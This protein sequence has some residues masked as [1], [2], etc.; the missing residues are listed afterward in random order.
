MQR[1][2]ARAVAALSV[3]LVVAIWGCGNATTVV[4]SGPSSGTATSTR[5]T[6]TATPST[7]HPTAAPT[8]TTASPYFVHMA[9]SANRSGDFTIIDNALTNGQPAAILIVTPNWNPPGS[10]GIYD[11][12]PIGVYY[13][14]GKWTIFHQD[15][16][17]IP[18]GAAFNVWVPP[19]SADPFVWTVTSGNVA[20]S[21]TRIKRTG[22]DFNP[23]AQLLITP[24]WNP[25]GGNGIY[26]NHAIGVYFAAESWYIY[27]Q[28]E[29]PLTVGAS[30]NVV[31]MQALGGYVAIATLGNSLSD[32][33]LL[34]AG[35]TSSSQSALLFITANFNPGGGI[36]DGITSGI[37]N[38]HNT[39]VSWSS[40]QWAVFNQDQAAMRS[41][42]A[43]NTLTLGG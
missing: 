42:V 3:V 23:S 31:N 9:T 12:H 28:D 39:G 43:F 35:R 13:T 36:A 11:D 21:V 29:V 7:A 4:Q 18:L 38:N 20:G 34:P 6:V 32:F 8:G 40:N 33:M 17:P 41:G 2:L 22:L 10:R 1:N 37:Y 30:F 16:T 25:T 14:S 15:G 5:P 27:N 26:D 24:T 19:A